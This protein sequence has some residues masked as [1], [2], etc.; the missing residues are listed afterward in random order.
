MHIQIFG[1]SV[2]FLQWNACDVSGL[3]MYEATICL[4]VP[5]DRLNF[6]CWVSPGKSQTNNWAFVSGSN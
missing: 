3:A 5:L 6:K 4:L 1:H 2:P